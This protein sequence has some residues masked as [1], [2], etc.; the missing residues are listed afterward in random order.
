MEILAA[1]EMPDSGLERWFGD[2][3]RFCEEHG[4]RRYYAEILD[5]IEDCRSA[6]ADKEPGS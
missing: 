5:L 2:I 4:G 3:Q 6:L 1:L